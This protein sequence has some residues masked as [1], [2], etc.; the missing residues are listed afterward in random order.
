[1][2]VCI[3]ARMHPPMTR[4]HPALTSVAL[5]AYLVP[6]ACTTDTPDTRAADEGAS[7]VDAAAGGASQGLADA[8][9]PDD[10]STG[11]AAGA[12][13]AASGGASTGLPPLE[14]DGGPPPTECLPP[15]LYDALAACNIPGAGTPLPDPN[16]CRHMPYGD[17]GIVLCDPEAGY[18]IGPAIDPE[19]DGRYSNG[20]LCLRRAGPTQISAPPFVSWFDPS[21]ELIA[22]VEV[23]PQVPRIPMV[24]AYCGDRNDPDTPVYEM[25]LDS[26]HC[27]TWRYVYDL[28]RSAVSY[29]YNPL[30]PPGGPFCPEGTCALYTLPDE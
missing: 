11:G 17:H 29:R 24:R 16:T 7:A 21:G 22:Q 14:W 8:S 28:P 10:P 23:D 27:R 13:G 25:D 18:T 26:P 30:D 2:A 12:A 1:M 9:V 5:A 4:L 20:E 3:I 19:S 6:A 15:C